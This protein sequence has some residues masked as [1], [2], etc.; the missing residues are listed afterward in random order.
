VASTS[1]LLTKQ[2]I[3]ACFGSSTAPCPSIKSA[4]TLVP[5][6]PFLEEPE[7]LANRRVIRLSADRTVQ[8]QQSGP[9]H[10]DVYLDCGS[11]C[12]YLVSRNETQELQARRL[13]NVKDISK[14][15]G[16]EDR[17]DTA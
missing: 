12:F 2:N 3:T 16:F 13:R 15:K 10:S 8:L 17:T 11:W 14:L 7:K 6:Y 4:V 9:D 5:S 1:T